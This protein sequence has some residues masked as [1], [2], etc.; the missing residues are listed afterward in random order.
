MMVTDG[1][2]LLCF[3]Q[4]IDEKELILMIWM[5]NETRRTWQRFWDTTIKDRVDAHK[6][7]MNWSR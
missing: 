1:V 5:D 3:V 4:I 6:K 7:D 2:Q